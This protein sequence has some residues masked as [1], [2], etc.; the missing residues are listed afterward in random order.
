LLGIGVT[1]NVSNKV[2][3]FSYYITFVG[4]HVYHILMQSSAA[5]AD[6]FGLDTLKP[7]STPVAGVMGGSN[8]NRS[9]SPMNPLAGG[10]ASGMGGGMG[11]G[12]AGKSPM[13]TPNGSMGSMGGGGGVMGGGPRMQQQSQ[14]G[15]MGMGGPPQRGMG[16]PG[17][18]GTPGYDPFNNIAGLNGLQGRGAGPNGRR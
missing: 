5:S 2:G 13:G 3:K 18:P 15:G 12:M 4:Y 11:G 14:G 17:G 16:G 6:L 7:M 8:N 1:E 10:M 9:H